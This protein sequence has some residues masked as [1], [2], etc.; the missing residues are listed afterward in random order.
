MNMDENK[1][2][3]SKREELLILISRLI[4][5]YWKYELCFIAGLCIWIMI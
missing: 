2:I 4:K 5:R 1:I 3:L